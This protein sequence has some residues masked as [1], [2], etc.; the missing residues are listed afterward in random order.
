M[1]IPSQSGTIHITCPSCWKQWDWTEGKLAGIGFLSDL[2]ERARRSYRLFFSGRF[3]C[4][5]LAIALAAGVAIG[6][7]IDTKLHLLRK[8]K[9]EAV[10]IPTEPLTGESAATNLLTPARVG[11]KIEDELPTN[12]QDLK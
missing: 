4:A 5:H 6:I 11:P 1:R 7:A 10:F 9:A 3:S 2:S 8:G 12:I